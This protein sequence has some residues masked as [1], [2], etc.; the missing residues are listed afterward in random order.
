MPPWNA[1]PHNPAMSPYAKG[2]GNHYT[3]HAMEKKKEGG[4]G[5]QKT[6]VQNQKNLMLPDAHTTCTKLRTIAH[7]PQS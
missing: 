4:E 2:T 6:T 5:E 7:A 1:Q 3:E